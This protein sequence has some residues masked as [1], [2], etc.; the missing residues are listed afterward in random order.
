MSDFVIDADIL[1]S[2]GE[3][4]HPHSSNAKRLLE[5]IRE[6]RHRMVRCV[7]LN[8]E[9]KKHRSRFSSLWM[10]AMISKRLHVVWEYVEDSDLRKVILNPFPEDASKK[11]TAVL[12]DAHLL[13]AAAKT[14]KRILSKDKTAKNLFQASCGQLGKYGEILWGD[15]TTS[16]DEI[17]C[18]VADGAVERNEL[19]ICPKV[20][21][22]RT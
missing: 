18:W 1:R 21:K 12:K 2:A 15:M 22:K 20:T 19:R 7:P 13:E 17:I 8:E 3:T 14:G 6:K 5:T 4:E 16:P 10:S 11:R 9:H